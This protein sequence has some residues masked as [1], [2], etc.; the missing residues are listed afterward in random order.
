MATS[1][2]RLNNQE[3]IQK[4]KTKELNQQQLGSYTIYFS[5]VRRPLCP[6]W[7]WFLVNLLKQLNALIDAGSKLRIGAP[8]S[9]VLSVCRKAV[10][11][12]KP[13]VITNAILHGIQ[14]KILFYL[15]YVFFLFFYRKLSF[16]RKMCF[17]QEYRDRA[18]LP[19]MI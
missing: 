11:T 7:S 3:V 18:V 8:S 16:Y 14:W 1:S 15:L 17:C 5:S 4:Y 10:K 12:R 2:I 6:V 19:Y 9:D 13:D